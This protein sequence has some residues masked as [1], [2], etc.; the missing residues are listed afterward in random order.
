MFSVAEQAKRDKESN[1]PA[2]G[3]QSQG[4]MTISDNEFPADP[5]YAATEGYVNVRRDI[6]KKS[7]PLGMTSCRIS[8]VYFFETKIIDCA[9]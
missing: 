6:S 2:K 8:L 4:I 3:E 9:L 1:P 7:T 5:K